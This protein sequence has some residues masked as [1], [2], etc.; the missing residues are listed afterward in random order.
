MEAKENKIEV[1]IGGQVYKLSASESEGYMKTVAGYID[2]KLNEINVLKAA[3]ALNPNIRW[4]LLSL[5][6]ADEFFKEQD[7]TI[8]LE[9]RLHSKESELGYYFKE[10]GLLQEENL[11]L[12]DKISDLQ[13]EMGKLKADLNEFLVN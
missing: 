8:E 9:E 3:A 10:I 7:K 11:L 1:M 6:I 5:N 2:K 13:L 4:L 12:N